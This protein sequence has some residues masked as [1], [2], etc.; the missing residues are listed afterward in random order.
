[1]ALHFW[2]VLSTRLPR[3]SPFCGS[4][5]ALETC[6]VPLGWDSK[7]SKVDVC[8]CVCG[9]LRGVKVERDEECKDRKEGGWCREKKSAECGENSRFAGVDCFGTPHPPVSL[10]RRARHFERGFTP[11][12]RFS[13]VWACERFSGWMDFYSPRGFQ[14]A[15]GLSSDAMRCVC[16]QLGGRDLPHSQQQRD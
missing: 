14:V 2:S 5:S 11:T 9:G 7:G 3:F 6:L 4:F 1:M 8:L 13:G 12:G 10:N 16:A 15:R